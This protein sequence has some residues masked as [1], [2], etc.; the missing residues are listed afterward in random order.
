[1]ILKLCRSSIIVNE[2]EIPLLS[3]GNTPYLD[4]RFL[5]V[6][7]DSNVEVVNV[8]NCHA[9]C[10][11]VDPKRSIK[12]V[13]QGTIIGSPADIS[14]LNKRR[15]TGC[16]DCLIGKARNP[17]AA[18]GSRDKH[19]VEIPFAMVYLDVCYSS[20]KKHPE[21]NGYM[22]TFKDGYTGFTNV[23]PMISK[24]QTVDRFY[25]Y[26]KW[27]ETQFPPFKVKSIYTDQGAEYIKSKEFKQRGQSNS[28]E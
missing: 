24:I 1:M 23:Y 16:I 14:D 25:E 7:P 27:V 10:G 13:K 5:L 3:D 12:S 22:I 8:F 21:V 28:V 4:P 6:S 18:P 26:I 19:K 9:R 17:N 2:D 15:S 11:H 20:S